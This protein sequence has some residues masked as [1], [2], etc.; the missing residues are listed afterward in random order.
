MTGEDGKSKAILLD[1]RDRIAAWELKYKPVK[2]SLC[3]VC[4]TEIY[5]WIR[6]DRIREDK[7][8][9][10]YRALFHRNYVTYDFAVTDPRWLD[11]LNLLPAGIY[12]HSTFAP[13]AAETW[14]TISLSEAYF[15]FHY[16]LVA[17]VIVRDGAI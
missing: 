8:K 11:Q 12:P 7:G 5:W 1:H 14:L 13:A 17:A 10:K 2:S 6:E 15:G 16:K 9:R 3:L 4:P